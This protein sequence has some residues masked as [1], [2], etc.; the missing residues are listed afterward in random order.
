MNIKLLNKIFSEYNN[1]SESEKKISDF[2]INNKQN[3]VNMTIAD[4]ALKSRVSEA[5]VSRFCKKCGVKNFYQ[6]KISLAKEISEN[7]EIIPASNTIDRKNISLSLKNILS[8]KIEELTQTISHIDSE[9]LQ[10]ILSLIEKSETVMFS[11]VGNTIPV[12]L[13]GAYKF[14]QIGIR[15]VANSVWETQSA[16]AFNLSQKDLL[17]VISNSGAS[18]RLISLIENVKEKGVPVLSITNSET[19]PVALFSHYHITTA[20]REKLFLDDY[21]FSRISASVV[22]EIFYL[23]LTAG[24]KSACENISRHEQSIS[25]DKV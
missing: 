19:S 9:K 10:N 14:N 8:N 24:M 3:A 5:S 16:F 20:T 11:A 21:Y 4:L 13:D 15:A 17:I 2:I 1:F 6:L 23:F 12:A 7:N 25:E 22:I 18:K